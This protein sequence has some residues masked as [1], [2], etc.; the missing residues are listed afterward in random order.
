M[1]DGVE[2]NREWTSGGRRRRLQANTHVIAPFTYAV[3]S[4]S[5]HSSCAHLV[6]SPPQRPDAQQLPTKGI[7]LIW[8][9]SS[10]I[11]A[12][13][14]AERHKRESRGN[15]DCH[16]QSC[17]QQQQRVVMPGSSSFTPTTDCVVDRYI[18]DSHEQPLACTK[19]RQK[20]T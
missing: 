18:A 20:S 13:V 4:S 10:S 7:V 1:M 14:N 5:L 17:T 3:S 8:S 16:L 2:L 11:D 12:K 15:L 6:K 19:T 9:S